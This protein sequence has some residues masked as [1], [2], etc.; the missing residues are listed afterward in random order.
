MLYRID[1]ARVA[2]KY[3]SLCK[4]TESQYTGFLRLLGFLHDDEAIDDPRHAAYM[5]ATVK[6]ECA[7][8]W[9]PIEERGGR[10]W[11]ERY[12]NRKDLG[13]TQPGD[14]Y[15]F[16]GRGFCQITGRA[17]YARM[18]V[19]LGR[20]NEFVADPDLLLVPETSY[21]VMSIGMRRGLFTGK[22]LLTYINDNVSDYRNARR[23][24]NG[25]DKAE[26]IA[27]YAL[28]FERLLT[29]G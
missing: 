2:S 1:L 19:A 7:D 9:Q 25:L 23:I 20:G 27:N 22:A 16:R 24:I 5:L 6:H 8:T 3:A 4:L 28:L 17:N 11:C 15:L 10:E 18:G 13:N 26:L 21:A 14:G 29:R 12:E